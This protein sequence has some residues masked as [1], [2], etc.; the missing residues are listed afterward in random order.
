MVELVGG[1]RFWFTQP[2][3]NPWGN[4]D[5]LDKLSAGFLD[6][7]LDFKLVVGT[8]MG[9][10]YNRD[11]FQVQAREMFPLM[12]GRDCIQFETALAINKYRLSPW[13][14]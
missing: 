8:S 3:P 12:V 14:Q 1:I 4:R 7:Y 2:P 9:T 10:L 6:W 5:E 11:G 13:C